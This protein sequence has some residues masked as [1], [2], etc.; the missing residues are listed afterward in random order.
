MC[1]SQYDYQSRA[2][3]YR[4]GVNILEKQ[5]NHR[6]K[7][8]KRLIKNREHKHNIKGNHQATKTMI[9]RNKEET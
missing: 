7:A 8:Y 4:K 6:S 1:L 9:K 3:R 2:S 5:G